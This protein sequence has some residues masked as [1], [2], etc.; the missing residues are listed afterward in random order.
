MSKG[1]LFLPFLDLSI[2]CL[3][4]GGRLGFV[5]SNRWQF[6]AFA[7]DFR[8]TRLPEIAIEQN[9][10]LELRRRLHPER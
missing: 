3:M 2:G 8:Q 9:K 6:M 5:C 7:S 4:P 1:D 10:P